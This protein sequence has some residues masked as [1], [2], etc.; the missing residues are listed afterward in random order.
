M[1]VFILGA[2]ASLE[3]TKTNSLP[4]PLAN[5]FFKKEYLLKHWYEI[6]SNFGKF[7]ESPLATILSVYFGVHIKGNGKA[8]IV[9]GA[10]NVEEVYS[11]L[12]SFESN[13][14]AVSFEREL[15]SNAR[16][17]LLDY[18]TRVIQGTIYTHDFDTY[19]MLTAD[20]RLSKKELKSLQ[21]KSFK[22]KRK[23][24]THFAI[25][26]ILNR[27][28]TIISFNWDL[29]P[30]TV[31]AFDRKHSHYF[32]SR[33]RIMSPFYA[34]QKTPWR[35]ASLVNVKQSDGYLLKMHG[36]VNM[37]NCTNIECLRNQFPYI[38]DSF[39]AE[40]P[41]VLFCDYCG[42]PVEIL[43]VPPSIKKTY[44]ANR[45]FQLQANIASSRLHQ[46][47]EII[48]IGYSFPSFDFDSSS[49][50]RLARLD[51]RTPTDIETVLHKVTIVNP[52]V[53]DE[54]YVNKVK[55]LFGISYPDKAH[56]HK[57]EIALYD[58]VD[59]Y[60]KTVLKRKSK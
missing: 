25:S 22:E 15:F 56:H 55:D 6:E 58:N 42:S 44:K 24:K 34:D 21:I 33:D 8:L 30:E 9:E 13:Y 16:R 46:A 38:L 12:E 31:L 52:E 41:D 54:K 7:S 48:V 11:F 14:R 3:D 49:L 18:V 19:R 60:L 36:S 27:Q 37:C 28:D 47:H 35:Q 45:F 2:G 53:N 43:I 4:M 23:F 40:V 59:S 51:P 29:L 17:Q 57:V 26:S 50:I 1:R 39:D 5:D 20:L 10:P 32:Q